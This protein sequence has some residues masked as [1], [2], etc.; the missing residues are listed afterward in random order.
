MLITISGTYDLQASFGYSLLQQNE[1]YLQCDTSVAPVVINLPLIADFDGLLNMKVF[2][3]DLS[4]NA[5]TNNISILPASGN[6][7]NS[8]GSVVIDNNSGSVSVSI[9]STNKWIAY[10]SH[11]SFPVGSAY[12]TIQD[13][14]SAL[15]NRTVMNFVGGGVTASDVGGITQISIPT[16]QAYNTIQDE[17]IALPQRQIIDFQGLGVQATDVGGKTVVTVL[18]G[19]PATAYGLYAQTVSSTPI[20]ATIVESTLIG[21]GV[22]TLSVPANGFFVGGSFRADLGGLMSAKNNDTIRI[23]VKTLGGVILLD[24]GTQ[25][26]PSTTNNVWNLGI[27]FTI[28]TL[29]VAGVA[30]IVSLGEF[31]NTKTSNG[32]QEGFAFNTINN[33]TFDTTISNTLVVTAQWSSTSALN[34]IYSDIF[35]LNKIY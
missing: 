7:I 30:S 35:V 18:S 3:T 28:R 29:G 16:Q 6:T 21:A 10:D 27:N 33:T 12:N 5:F 1:I 31:H 25:T 4:N 23:R 9:A 20:T 13:E 24:S 2:V 17:S 14:G 8:L 32:T 26:M 11:N 19:L 34:S 22:G 15:P